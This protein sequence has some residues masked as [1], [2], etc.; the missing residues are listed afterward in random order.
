MG[1]RSHRGP[2]GHVAAGLDEK[3]SE[4]AEI[5]HQGAKAGLGTTFQ[6]GIPRRPQAARSISI[7][8]RLSVPRYNCFVEG[9]SRTKRSLLAHAQPFRDHVLPRRSARRRMKAFDLVR[10]QLHKSSAWRR[11]KLV[12]LE[13]PVMVG[14]GRFE[15]LLDLS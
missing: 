11:R 12:D 13:L 10:D 14:I 8:R 7:G 1:A 6:Q 2:V 15:A 3:T 9:G 5:C 4:G